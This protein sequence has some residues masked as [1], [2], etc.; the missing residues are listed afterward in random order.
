[1]C[2][3]EGCSSKVVYGVEWHGLSQFHDGAEI[4]S[5]SYSCE[6][7]GHL[8]ALSC[9]GKYASWCPDRISNVNTGEN[10]SNLLEIVK[11]IMAGELDNQTRQIIGEL[12][13]VANVS[14]GQLRLFPTGNILKKAKS[15]GFEVDS[16]Q[17]TKL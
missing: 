6:N 14:K 5:V 15:L 7:P 16:F 4:I 1:M 3:Y 13:D 12:T 9:P 8:I 2:N 11:K 10:K 17:N